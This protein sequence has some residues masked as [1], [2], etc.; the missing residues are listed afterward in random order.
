ML[1]GKKEKEEVIEKE[2]TVIGLVIQFTP[3]AIYL[4]VLENGYIEII[5]GAIYLEDKDGYSISISGTCVNLELESE[6]EIKTIIRT[7]QLE[8]SGLPIIKIPCKRLS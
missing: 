8:E 7:Y 3:N 5:D 1:F 6:K 4:Y 2:K